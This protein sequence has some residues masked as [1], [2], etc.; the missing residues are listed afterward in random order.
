VSIKKA[1]A[2]LV[3]RL[4]KGLVVGV[5]VRKEL[6]RKGRYN[7]AIYIMFSYVEHDRH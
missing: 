2:L 5:R 4:V 7:S 1:Q 3:P 6:R